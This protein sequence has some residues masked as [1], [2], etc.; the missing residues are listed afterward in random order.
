[1]EMGIVPVLEESEDRYNPLTGLL[2]ASPHHIS[3]PPWFCQTPNDLAFSHW[4][5]FVAYMSIPT[6]PIT[7]HNASSLHNSPPL[8]PLST[9]TFALYHNYHLYFV[10]YVCQW[11]LSSINFCNMWY[12]CTSLVQLY[13]LFKVFVL[14]FA[15]QWY[16]LIL[17]IW[18]AWQRLP[19]NN[20]IFD[21]LDPR[22]VPARLS[23]LARAQPCN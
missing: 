22:L 10:A 19:S 3:P 21:F 16:H 18:F 7:G 12:H 8:I 6:D 5:V 15:S 9:H 4:L 1:M 2:D 14:A 20:I 11:F 13:R 17:N 23:N